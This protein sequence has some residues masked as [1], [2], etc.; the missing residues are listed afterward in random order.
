MEAGRHGSARGWLTAESWRQGWGEAGR[1]GSAGCCAL[2]GMPSLRRPRPRAR[3]R[4]GIGAP[5]SFGPLR[6][7]EQYL[8]F[9]LSLFFQTTLK[10]VSLI[11]TRPRPTHSGDGLRHSFCFGSR[12][13]PHRFEATGS[14]MRE[15]LLLGVG[16]GQA[17]SV[18]QSAPG[19]D[20]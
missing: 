5:E 15:L 17:R 19:W 8:S 13:Q 4:W 20:L 16:K 2:A 10:I 6:C 12:R 18:L 9:R 11:A 14:G 1:S 3:T 7:R